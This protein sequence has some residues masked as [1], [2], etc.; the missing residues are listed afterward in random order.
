M[1]QSA[2]ELID[3]RRLRRKLG[4][5]RVAAILAAGAAVVALPFATGLAQ[6]AS[7]A[8]G[9]QI[10]RV[11]IEGLITEDDDLLE[12]LEEL[13]DDASVK[14]LVLRIDSPGG[15][16]V[17]GE[18]IYE[19]VRA[20]A[21]TKP[22]VAEVGTLAASAGYMIAA[23]TDHIVARRTSIVG[24]IGVIFQ[25]VD[26]S[27]LLDKVGVAVNAI[28]SAPLKAE[29]SPFAPAPEAAKAMISRLVMD[30]YDWFVALV[31]ERRGLGLEATRI[32]ADGSIFSGQQGLD[33]KLVD[34]LG[35]EGEV[36][37]WLE[38]E[39]GV[40]K[41]LEIVDREPKDSGP[42]F[43]LLGSARSALY[44]LVGLDPKAPDLSTALAREAGHLDGLVS[45]WQPR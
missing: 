8:L 20:I 36:R 9:D 18:T 43:P 17:G 27:V 35:G 32:L 2:D 40:A 1:V 4:F 11:E 7:P 14:A 23:G 15:T 44:G 21:A 33:A 24:S 6:R 41:G 12:L 22:V 19:A 45:L 28:K 16:T 13:K 29:P 31:A 5:W 34:A 10:A 37:R 30:T 26:A 3:R 38:E 25:Y 42:G 39:R